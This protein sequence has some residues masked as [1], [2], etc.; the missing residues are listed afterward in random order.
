MMSE[1]Q[2]G[3]GL[4]R[5]KELGVED[6]YFFTEEAR[7]L[8]REI[9]T[10]P[11]IDTFVGR[12]RDLSAMFEYAREKKIDLR[13]R[14]SPKK[15]EQLRNDCQELKNIQERVRQELLELQEMMFKGGVKLTHEDEERV[16]KGEMSL[17]KDGGALIVS[18]IQDGFSRKR[19]VD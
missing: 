14:I 16:R 1:N 13:G 8:T 10:G 2:P 5:T 12:A 7:K 15:F 18:R 9:N 17:D 3:S 4:E 6:A 11:Q 19:G